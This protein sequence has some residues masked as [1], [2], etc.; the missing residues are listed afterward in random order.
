MAR[1]GGVYW[2]VCTNASS[3]VSKRDLLFW[4]QISCDAALFK[5]SPRKFSLAES[6][7]H[8]ILKLPHEAL[9]YLQLR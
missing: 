6:R 5:S 1:H 9:R 7:I 4:F 8:F 3:H 2:N